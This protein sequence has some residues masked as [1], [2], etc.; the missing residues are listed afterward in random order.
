[1]YNVDMTNIISPRPA[2]ILTEC[3]DKAAELLSSLATSSGFV[4]S[5]EDRHNYYR[6]WSRDGVIMGL[7]GLLFGD[8]KLIEAFRQT[9]ETLRLFQDETGRIPSNVSVDRNKVSYGTSV[10][11]VDATIWYIIGYTELL[12]KKQIEMTEE[13][14]ASLKKAVL[15]LNC[16]ELNGKHLLYVPEGGDWADEY[17]NHGYVLFDELL[18]YIALK[19]TARALGDP[20]AKEKAEILKKVL[21][22][23][24]FPN[25]KEADQ[26]YIYHRALYEKYAPQYIHPIPLSYFNASTYSY[27]M[28]GF[29]LAIITLIDIVDE[30][31][32]KDII[33]AMHET[34]GPHS[35]VP[36][37]HPIITETD[38][39]WLQLKNN[40]LFEF[41]NK[42][43]EYHNGGLWPLVHGL[44][45]AGSADPEI[46]EAFAQTLKSDNYNFPEFYSGKTGVGMGVQP[47][48]FSA[49]AYLIAHESVIN[50]KA[51]FSL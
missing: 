8:E 26:E 31:H 17:I 37:F 34:A 6:V 11:R 40:Y 24:Y 41:R 20:L 38:P 15:Y 18:Y 45:T 14:E 3:R 1:M 29:A 47:S 19:N 7:A 23:N 12:L 36:A 30:D 28:D 9:L 22:T 4:A 35:L 16:L 49:S 33:Y 13:I 48:G 43:H 50:S 25:S 21:V 42:P 39:E 10:G 27:R 5:T 44:Y 51:I 32:K 2:K 46:L